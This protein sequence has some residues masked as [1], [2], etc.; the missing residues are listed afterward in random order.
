MI[1][2][3]PY[4]SQMD[5]DSGCITLLGRDHDQ[6]YIATGH[7]MTL[8]EA[9]ESLAAAATGNLTALGDDLSGDAMANDPGHNDFVL[10]ELA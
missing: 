9:E 7:G 6:N 8:G 1:L 2:F 3:L 4:V 5:L 10:V